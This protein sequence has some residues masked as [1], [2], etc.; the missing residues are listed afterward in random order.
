MIAS[1]YEVVMPR[2]YFADSIVTTMK[3]GKESTDTIW[4]KVNNVTLQNQLGET[5]SLDQLKGK[6]ILVDFFF[7]H[8]ASICPTL[9][10]NIKKTAGRAEGDRSDDM[11]ASIT[12]FL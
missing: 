5:V 11:K 7:T 12:S 1:R 8:C 2:H 3:D 9:T 6:V 4:H 10:R